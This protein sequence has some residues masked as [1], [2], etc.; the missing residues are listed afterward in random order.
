MTSFSI[1]WLGGAALTLAVLAGS[2]GAQ[3]F[4]PYYGKNKVKYD[5]LD[6]QVYRSPHF[7]IYYYPEFEQELGRIVSYAESAY[8]RISNELKHEISF[9]IPMIVYKT[10]SEFAQTNLFPMEIPEGVLAFAEPVRTRLVLPIDEPPDKLMELITH[11][12]THIFE[13]DIIPRPLIRQAVPLWVDEGLA[14]YMSQDSWESMDLMKV[15]DAAVTDQLPS[16]QELNTQFSR[17]PYDFGKSLFE[18]MEERFGKEGIRQFL[19]ALRKSVLGGVGSEVYQQAF[20]MDEEE[21]NRQYRKWL[22]ERFK[23]F[24]DKEIPEDYSRNLSPDPRKGRYVAALSAAPS[25]SREML[26]VMSYNMRDGELDVVLLSAKDGS[27]IKNLTP[28]YTGHFEYIPLT[29]E[30]AFLGRM[31]A[32]TPD[33]DHVAFFGRYKKRRALILVN[34]LTAEVDRRYVMSLDQ[35]SFPEFGSEGKYLY[36]SGLRDGVSDIWRLDLETEEL[37]N[38]TKDRFADKFPVISPDGKWLHYCRRVSGNEKI[39]RLNLE[40]P[41]EKEQMTFGTF[42]D[43][44]PTF[45]ADGKYLFY[46]SNEDDNIYNVRSLDLETGDI[47][48]YTDVL[49]GNFAPAIVIGENDSEQIIF[50]SYYKSEYGLYRLSMDNPVK[51]IPADQIAR[52]EGPVIDFVPPVLHQVIPENKRKKGTF[53]KM[54]IDGAPPISVGVT[55]GGDFYGGT[56]ISFS[57]VLGDKNFTFMAISV[58]EFRTYSGSFTNLSGRLQYSLQGFDSTSFFFA[59]PYSYSYSIDRNELGTIRQSG[60]IIS[61]F[62]P[63]DR[64][65]R[66]Q[67][68]A[69]IIRQ[70]SGFQNACLD[71]EVAGSRRPAPFPRGVWDQSRA[72]SECAHE[73]VPQRHGLTAVHYLHSRDNPLP[74]VRASCG[75]HGAGQFQFLARW[76]LFVAAYDRRRC[77]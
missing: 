8:E 63:L 15:R 66:I 75:E 16:S 49:G 55:S 42:D 69:G 51:E 44:G 24:R 40:N 56:G 14:E 43:V 72:D 34:V 19:F 37:A 18:F 9:A 50:T 73:P 58:R 28:G 41:D 52:T 4:A 5:K 53:E 61:A 25:P 3:S 46:S 1:R 7:E 20:R 70:R 31:L 68:S 29:G 30:G 45:S 71:P 65:K 23:P 6:W 57:D 10:F 59:S 36:F 39:Y 11:E 33:G 64:F 22:K 38:M 67:F 60:G 21:F 47:L 27:V 2:A 76:G 48:Q 54:Y 74:P 32:W 12:L 77:P 62:Y 26:A 35:A 17:A 13:F